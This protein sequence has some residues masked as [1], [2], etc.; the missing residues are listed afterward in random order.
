MTLEIG[1]LTL[2]VVVD[3]DLEIGVRG[4]VERAGDRG[5]SG[6]GVEGNV[7]DQGEVLQTVRPVI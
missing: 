3:M 1:H 7:V 4:A 6:S 2:I 5:L